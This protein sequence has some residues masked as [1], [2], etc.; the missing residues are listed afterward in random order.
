MTSMYS[1]STRARTAGASNVRSTCRRAPSPRREASSRSAYEARDVACETVSLSDS[2]PVCS[3]ITM[4]RVPPVAIAAM[5]TPRAAASSS[6]RLS[7]SGP[8]DGN[9]S[10]AAAASS[11][12]PV[13]RQP[14]LH[15]KV[16]RSSV[17]GR[18]P[19]ELGTQPAISYHHEGNQQAD[20]HARGRPGARR[21]CSARACRRRARTARPAAAACCRRRD[22]CLR[23][24]PDWECAGR[25]CPPTPAPRL[26]IGVRVPADG[27][28][29]IGCA[30]SFTLAPR[31]A[32]M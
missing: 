13:A 29:G 21:L 2:R 31:F 7:D 28:D 4:S 12:A 18:L 1:C 5:G 30:Q 27:D 25:R 26:Q 8:C 20:T 6:T 14:A 10:T 11:R 16:D 24:R 9:T 3:W 32:R 15:A 22:Q 23:C 17:L 19:F